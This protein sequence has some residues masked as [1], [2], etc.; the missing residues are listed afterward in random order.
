MRRIYKY[1]L[2]ISHSQTVAIHDGA[3]VLHVDNQY[4]VL[5]MWAEVNVSDTNPTVYETVY[6]VGTGNPV[7]DMAKHHLGSVIIDP[8][9]WHVYAEDLSK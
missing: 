1:P 2:H 4:G 6:V 3:K 9:V 8:F 5:T 7:P